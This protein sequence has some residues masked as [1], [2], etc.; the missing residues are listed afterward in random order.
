MAG[1][2]LINGTDIATH[3]LI[4]DAGGLLADPPPRGDLIVFDFQPGGV[5]QA[6]EPDVLT[7]DVFVVMVH[8]D[9]PGQTV[10]LTRRVDRGAGLVDETCTAVMNEAVRIDWDFSV[11]QLMQAVVTFTVLSGGWVAS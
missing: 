7:F 6:G 4:R 11:R 9:E 5:W 2:L 10:T 3:A 8:K 1:T